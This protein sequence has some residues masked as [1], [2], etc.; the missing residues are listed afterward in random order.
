MNIFLKVLKV[1]LIWLSQKVLHVT[2]KKLNFKYESCRK[3]KGIIVFEHRI[4][5]DGNIKVK[6]IH[7]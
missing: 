5:A 6:Q 7:H 4:D 2:G 1:Q 3:G